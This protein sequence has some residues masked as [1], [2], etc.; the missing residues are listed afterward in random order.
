MMRTQTGRRIKNT[1]TTNLMNP[2][3]RKTKRWKQRVQARRMPSES[4][5][6]LRGFAISALHLKSISLSPILTSHLEYFILFI[7]LSLPLCHFR[8]ACCTFIAI[9]DTAILSLYLRVFYT[10]GIGLSITYHVTSYLSVCS[11]EFGIICL[12][13][14]SPQSSYSTVISQLHVER[15]NVSRKNSASETVVLASLFTLSRL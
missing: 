8:A 5:C 12:S 2:L 1:K 10:H 6:L 14:A 7:S 4:S 3:S 9:S 13:Q 11:R 15:A